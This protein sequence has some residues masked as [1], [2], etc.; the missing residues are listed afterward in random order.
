[1][2]E[3][4]LIQEIRRRAGK[5]GRGVK[6]G[7]GDDCA[8]L[9]YDRKNYLLWASDML[10]EGTHFRV[11]D[12]T[13][14]KIGGKAVAVNASDIA[15]MGGVPK[16]I[17]VS[18][19][20]P[21]KVTRS[22]VKKIYDGIFRAC[23]EYGVRVIGGD[24]NASR[25]LTV[26]VSIIG[27]VERKT[28]LTRSGARE[29]QLVLIT[30]PVRDG[31]KRHMD[32]RPRLKEARFLATGFDIG[33]MIDVSDGIAMDA[34]RICAESRSGCRLYE[35][36]IPLEKGLSL[37]DA[38]YFGESF[39]LLFTMDVKEARKLFLD[40]RIKKQPPGYFVIGEITGKKD[41]LVL[42]GKEGRVE[43]LK[44]EGFRHLQEKKLRG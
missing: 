29:R 44:P 42:V 43:K 3:L 33:A 32:F 39:E 34:Y 13:Y 22:A 8:V 6:L 37:E 14:E 17:I 21:A 5:P 12:T 23:G 7:I 28:L 24:T 15:A 25:V 26:D 18:L 41:G 31:R 40:R 4:R 9:E 36:A 30:G 19:G 20:L 38:L 2:E 16:Y 10:V 35:E 27:T 1:M 11:K